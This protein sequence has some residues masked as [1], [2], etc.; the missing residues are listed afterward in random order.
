[1]GGWPDECDDAGTTTGGRGRVLEGHTL[2][3]RQRRRKGSSG[4]GAAYKRRRSSSEKTEAQ[5][6]QR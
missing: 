3:G 4:Q 2:E 6:K 1:M 5:P